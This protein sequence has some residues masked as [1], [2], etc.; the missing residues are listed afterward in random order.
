MFVGAIL[1]WIW[2][3]NLQKDPIP[4]TKP[5]HWAILPSKDLETLA[6][7]WE[8]ANSTETEIDPSTHVSVPGEDQKL[9]FQKFPNLYHKLVTKYFHGGFER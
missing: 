6:R 9:G 8:Y 4:P 3:P 2:I 5:M 7:G 1:A